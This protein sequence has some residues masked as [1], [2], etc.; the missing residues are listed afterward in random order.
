[1][2]SWSI[3][4]WYGQDIRTMAPEERRR[5]AE[6]SLKAHA[7]GIAAVDL[8]LCPFMNNLQPGALCNKAG[9]VCSIRLY[10]SGDPDRAA[11]DVQPTTT[12]PNRFLEKIDGQTVFGYIANE[13]FG[14][15]SGAKVV[16]EV[17]F[18]HKVDAT[19]ANRGSK[20]GRIDWVLVPKTPAPSE[21]SGFDWIAV[22]TQAVYFSGGAIWGDM[23]KYLAD[24]DNLHAPDVDRRPDFRS[25]GAKRLAPQLDAKSPVMRRWG[26]KVAVVV[27]EAFF[28]ELSAF[29][30][31]GTD[32]DNSEVV[33]VVL[34]FTDS[35][36]FEISRVVYAELQESIDALQATKPVN[37]TEF[38]SGLSAL[39]HREKSPKVYRA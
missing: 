10:E 27:D 8:P 1:M 39:L 31:D 9:G 2:S 7:E 12:C 14:V 30:D 3:A 36:K 29:R 5:S 13:L 24:P 21:H 17:P 38:E 28:A 35:M 23:R 11:D 33:W 20:A 6:L 26:R 18:L 4:E 25:S 15:T 37:K 32:F 34:R 16:K 19:G 22:E